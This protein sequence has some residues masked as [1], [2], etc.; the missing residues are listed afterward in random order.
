MRMKSTFSTLA[1]AAVLGLSLPVT[2]AFAALQVGEK[3]PDFKLSAA[4]AGKPTT[5]SLQQALKKGPVVLYFFPAAFTA[6][7]TLEAH[8]FAEATADFAKQG[9]TVIGV[10]AGNT[11]QIAKFSQ[12]ECRDKFTVAADPGAKVAAEYKNTMNILG[13][14]L[15]D[16]TSYVIAPDGKILLSYTDKN[17]DAHIQKALDAVKKYRQ[18]N[19]A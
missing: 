13:K 10:T 16:R 9:A 2:S 19:P 4:L 12:L 15:S 8:D 17:P 18:A 1:V 14:T 6:G 3:A 11:E 5:F 7:C